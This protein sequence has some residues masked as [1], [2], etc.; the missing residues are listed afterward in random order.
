MND[1]I[2][3]IQNL[4]PETRQHIMNL[5]KWGVQRAKAEREYHTVLAQEALKARESGMAIGII[6]LTVKGMDEVA[7]KREERDIADTMVTVC[8]E[9]IN[10][11]KLEAR[12]LEAQAQREW[13][14]KE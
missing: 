8:Q 13:S 1:L 2:T 6:E 12:L 11:S 9:M 3:R 4:I 10:I 7:L 14:V 5:Q